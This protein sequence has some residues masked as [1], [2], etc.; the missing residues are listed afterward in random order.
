MKK[1]LQEEKVYHGLFLGAETPL[2]LYDEKTT[3]PHQ[4]DNTE[5]NRIS[6]IRSE[7]V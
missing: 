2:V 3:R 4:R 6:M 7:F 5:L 1:K